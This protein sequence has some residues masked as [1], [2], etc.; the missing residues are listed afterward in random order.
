MKTSGRRG[1]NED[2][3][4]TLRP[5]RALSACGEVL[6]IASQGHLGRAVEDAIGPVN[7]EYLDVLIDTMGDDYMGSVTIDSVERTRQGAVSAALDDR[8][9][10]TPGPGRVRRRT[11]PAS[12]P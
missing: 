11:V 5:E 9:R 8:V 12:S 3:T 7:V 10:G 2:W 6:F 4:P 1:A